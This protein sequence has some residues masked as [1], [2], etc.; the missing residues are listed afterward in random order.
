MRVSIRPAC[1]GGRACVRA[2]VVPDEKKRSSRLRRSRAAPTSTDD[3]DESEERS[4][5]CTN[6]LSRKCA[7][8]WGEKGSDVAEV[9]KK[10]GANRT[11]A[12]E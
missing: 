9:A 2:G 4:V 10:A 6:Q 5:V 12:T 8:G 7:V 3:T 1:R 11:R